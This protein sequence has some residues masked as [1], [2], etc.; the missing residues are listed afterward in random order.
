[1]PLTA[2][3]DPIPNPSCAYTRFSHGG[4]LGYGL[5]TGAGRLIVKGARNLGTPSRQQVR[6]PLRRPRENSGSAE[7]S[8]EPG[9]GDD[10]AA[11]QVSHTRWR[12]CTMGRAVRE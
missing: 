5:G 12:R 11:P 6:I 2:A 7:M 8:T 4:W 10:R 1:V 9:E 3:A